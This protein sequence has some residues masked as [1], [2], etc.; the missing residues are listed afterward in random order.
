MYLPEG[1]QASHLHIM[2]GVSKDTLRLATWNIRA[3]LGTDLRR[4]AL[5]VIDGIA[6]LE[7]D[8]MVLQEADFRL[9][10]RPSALPR[11]L[12]TL[13][14]GLVPLP[15][16]KNA[17]SIG[18]HGNAVLVKPGIRLA[19]LELLNL[20]GLEPRGAIIADL[21]GPK[22]LRLVAVHLGLLRSSRRRQ[23][24]AIGAAIARRPPRGT[25]ILGDFNEPSR[26]V[27]LG[28]LVKSFRL[29]KPEA[30]YPSRVPLLALD[31]M[32]HSFDLALRPMPI[33]RKRGVQASDHL[34]LLAELHWT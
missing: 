11:D 30:T 20:P 16:G 7:V 9:G 22:P 4:D 17:A 21:N 18:W 8:V 15:V 2:E 13:H 23:L 31:R 33:P 19:G 10:A 27:G 1:S 3:G 32:A 12:L 34:P 28:R 6:A 25:V 24:D 26:S 14:A 5:R 29:R